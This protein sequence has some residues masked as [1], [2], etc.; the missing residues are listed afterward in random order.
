MKK[1]SMI[2]VA[3][4]TMFILVSCRD[5]KIQVGILQFVS[6]KDLDDARIGF[7]ESLEKEGFIDGDNIKITLINAQTDIPTMQ[8]G[9]STLV[10]KSDI[11]LGIATPAAIALAN[12]VREMKKDTPLLFTAVTDPVDAKLVDSIEKPGANITG[13]SDMNRI[14][15]QISLIPEIKPE[16]K[17]VGIIYSASEPNSKVQADEAVKEIELLGLEAVTKTITEPSFIQPILGTLIKE[18]DVIYIPSDNLIS[19]NMGAIETTLKANASHQVPI[20]AATTFQVEEG[21]SITF[22]F[23]YLNL[24]KQT[25]LM[26]AKILNGTNPSDLS[27]EFVKDTELVI[28]LKQ[29]K[30]VLKIEV[31]E[32]LLNKA[33]RIIE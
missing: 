18:V 20:I 15:Q 23:S 9:A 7:I 13:T 14:D 26:A 32:E 30:E 6:H 16:A 3:I 10:R 12:E 4:F 24:G 5:S 31:S 28:N 25:G 1:I 8:T 11:L 21:A 33:D 27:V 29:F 22:G 19:S 17:K 2:L